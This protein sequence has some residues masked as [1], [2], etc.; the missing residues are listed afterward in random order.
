M[1]AT[2]HF[3]ID[4][5]DLSELDD[6]DLVELARNGVH[7]AYATLYARHAYAAHRLARHLGM[8]D[9]AEDVVSESFA[10]VLE[11]M[12]R[13]KGPQT[14][15]RAYLFTT[16]RNGAA[17]RA[18]ARQKLIPTDDEATI[19][20][21]VGFDIGQLD[22]FELSAIR[23]AYD[24]LPE[25]WQTVLWQVEVERRKPHELAEALGLSPNGVSALAYRARAALRE[26]YLKQH[27][28]PV[29]SVSSRSC[30]E[31][32]DNLPGLVRGTLPDRRE[33]RVRE[34]LRGCADCGSIVL[35]LHDANHA[36]GGAARA[37]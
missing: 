27:I 17:R 3:R 15:F 22:A 37:G 20:S 30:R 25:R 12:Q 34:H 13:G 35:E 5:P 1:T 36:V 16:I 10:Q 32:Q 2:E 14:A 4:R 21:L 23:A 31:I 19:D 6:S 28:G 24:S 9:E 33:G 29:S 26:A 7:A 8:R 18:K 11:L